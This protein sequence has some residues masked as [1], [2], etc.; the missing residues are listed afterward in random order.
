MEPRNYRF[1]HRV[2]VTLPSSWFSERFC[3][4]RSEENGKKAGHSISSSDLQT[5][6]THTPTHTHTH[7]HTHALTHTHTHMTNN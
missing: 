5:P 4:K 3:L 1:T 6:P 2:A 7:A